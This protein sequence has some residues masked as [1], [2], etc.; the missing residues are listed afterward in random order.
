MSQV[1]EQGL[2]P[3][4]VTSQHFDVL[5]SFTGIRGEV[6]AAALRAHFVGGMSQRDAIQLTGV[7]QSLLSRKAAALQIMSSRLED[8]SK[9]YR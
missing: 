2:I 3:G 8:A 4:K 1:I 6:L 7:N 5:L 9:Y